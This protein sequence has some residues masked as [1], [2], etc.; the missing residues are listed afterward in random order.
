MF[1][2]YLIDLLDYCSII[3]LSFILCFALSCFLHLLLLVVSPFPLNQERYLSN[4][5]VRAA[6][7][8]AAST[9]DC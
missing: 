1:S 5:G 3:L 8:S 7:P 6:F 2:Q 4:D 9:G